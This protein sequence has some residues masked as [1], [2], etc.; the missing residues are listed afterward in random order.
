LDFSSFDDAALIAAI[1]GAH[2]K[3]ASLPVLNKALAELYER[4]GKLVYSIAYYS[5]GDTETAEEITQDVFLNACNNAHTYRT[6]K[7]KLSSW[8]ASIA[9]HRAIDELRRRNA[10][11]EKDQIDWPADVGMDLL[12]GVSSAENPEQMVEIT[13]QS[14]S[15]QQMI[16]ALPSDQR[17]A[18]ALAFF[19]GLSHKEIADFLGEPL[20]T[21]KSRVRLAMQKLRERMI[22]RGMIE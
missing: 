2:G 18:L 1:A 22:E 20:G 17:Q 8:L 6:E 19:R 21:I 12:P 10:R 7:A 15:I 13:M 14:E 3:H 9:R 16:A 5:V 4:Y 11:P